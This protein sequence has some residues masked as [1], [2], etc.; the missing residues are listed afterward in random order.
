MPLEEYI[1]RAKSVLEK[2]WMGAYTVPSVHLY[3]HQWN[4]D[5]GFIAIG[6]SH[7]DTE[8][9]I[10]E[11]SHLFKAQWKNGM[12]PQIVFNKHAL[13]KYFPEPDFWQAHKSPFAPE[14]ILTSG[15]TMP[16]IHGYVVL[17]IYE[18]APE[19]D[20]VIPFLKWIFP[21]IIKYHRYLYLERNPDDN[22]LIYIRHPWESGM[23]N[24]PLWDEILNRIDTKKVS[25]PHF[26]RKDNKIIDPEQ[27]PRD[28]DYKRYIYLVDIF[29]K[30]QYDEKKIFKECPFIAADPLFNSILC[31]SNKALIKIADILKED[32]REIEEWYKFTST[33]V[34][35]E[36]YSNKDRIFYGYDFIYKKH[37][38]EPTAAGFLPLFGEIPTRKQAQELLTYMNSASF[39]HIH[40]DNCFAIPNYDKKKKDFSR[41]NYWRG[42]VWININWMIY[43]GLLKYGFKQKAKHLEKTILELPMRFDFYEYFDS[44][45]GTGYGTKDF[46]WTAALFIDLAYRYKKQKEIKKHLP[47]FV[48]ETVLNKNKNRVKIKD[49]SLIYKKFNKIVK[50][51]FTR[52]V[53]DGLV[54]YKDIMVSPEYKI[55]KVVSADLDNFSPEILPVKERISFYINLY[56]IMVIDF[57]I[58]KKIKKTVLEIENFFIDL[59]YSVGGKRISLYDIEFKILKNIDDINIKRKIPFSLVRGTKTSPHLRFFRGGELDNLLDMCVKDYIASSE[60]VLIPEK[61]QILLPEF[62]KWH[63]DVFKTLEDVKKFFEGFFK[64]HRQ[65]QLENIHNLIF[66][67]HDWQLNK[68]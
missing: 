64:N 62:I 23:D 60:I 34:R 49:N 67:D 42:P 51:I 63:L 33:S 12:I 35:D 9:A 19:K 41:K 11:I 20:K 17:K 8:R 48:S 4:W 47:I 66:L 14:G 24:S 10:K 55:Y 1:S 59:K 58:S 46:S 15:I 65:K 50:S 38:K 39:C 25:I 31:A 21:K 68:P 30:N 2:N 61:K 37:L 52:Y 28:I 56:N 18:N 45:E 6:Y 27:R 32:Y 29:R 16:P 26:K 43:E 57:V 3:P 13:G 5:S 54:S 53:S 44:Y 36:L 7:Y 22:G 40:D